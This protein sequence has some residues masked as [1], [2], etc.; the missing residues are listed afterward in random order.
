MVWLALVIIVIAAFALPR[1]G[2]ALMSVVGILLAISVV[3]IL[4]LLASQKHKETVSRELISIPEVELTDLRLAPNYSSSYKLVGRVK[5]RSQQYTLGSF[6]M[7]ITARDCITDDKCETVGE[8]TAHAYVSV[9][10]GQSR[11]L[12]EH[13]SFSSL[14]T[15]KGRFSWNYTVTEV[16]G[17]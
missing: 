12:D 16:R 11:G 17:R 13:V 14:P 7:K 1:L 3:G 6:Q 10:P 5:N 4:V 9:P 15:F 8:T 2:I